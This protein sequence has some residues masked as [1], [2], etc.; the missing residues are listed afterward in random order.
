METSKAQIV[1]IVMERCDPEV[2]TTCKND[3]EF[4]DWL[5]GVYMMTVENEWTY[6]KDEIGVRKRLIPR[7]TFKMD[8]INDVIKEEK[9]RFLLGHKIEFQDRW[10]MSSLHLMPTD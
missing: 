10:L 7:S 1:E 8:R 6:Y 2:R 9:N 3:T 5:Q 4:R